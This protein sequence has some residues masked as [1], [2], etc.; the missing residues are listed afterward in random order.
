MIVEWKTPLIYL[1]TLCISWTG[2]YFFAVKFL[3]GREI[4]WTNAVNE[5]LNKKVDLTEFRSSVKGL[6]KMLE[7]GNTAMNNR[8][9]DMGRRIDDI[10]ERVTEVVVLLKKNGHSK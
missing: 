1:T 6:G 3:N 4:I 7:M 9:D 5:R 2:L 10:G 8:I